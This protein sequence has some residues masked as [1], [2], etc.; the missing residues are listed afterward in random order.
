MTSG[1]EA[2]ARR[3]Y[4]QSA[5]K[6]KDIYS[7]FGTVVG[8]PTYNHATDPVYGTPEGVHNQNVGGGEQL[9]LQRQR[10]MENQYGAFQQYFQHNDGGVT[11][12]YSG[13]DEEML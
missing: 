6:S 5:A 1:Y 11:T 13:D 12:G 3:E 8:G 7:H 10:A 9:L 2:L 4:E